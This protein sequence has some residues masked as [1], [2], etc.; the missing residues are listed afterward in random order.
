MKW[1]SLLNIPGILGKTIGA[2]MVKFNHLKM[3][4][5]QSFFYATFRNF[6]VLG[7]AIKYLPDTNRV[8]GNL[9]NQSSQQ[10]YKISFID[11]QHNEIFNKIIF[12]KN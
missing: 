10:T 6:C 2:K 9:K 3:F 1:E 11:W 5:K 4:Y 8:L 12:D 7:H